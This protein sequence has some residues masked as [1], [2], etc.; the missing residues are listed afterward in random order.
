V[1]S[2]ATFGNLSSSPV[3][4]FTED[5]RTSHPCERG[6]GHLRNLSNPQETGAAKFPVPLAELSC[7]GV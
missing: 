6:V 5:A 4:N 1:A 3:S 2:L 7:G